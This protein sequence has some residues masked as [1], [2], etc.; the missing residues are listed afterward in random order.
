[1]LWNASETDVP[2]LIDSGCSINLVDRL[3]TWKP[4]VDYQFK[5]GDTPK[6]HGLGTVAIDERR[7]IIIFKDGPILKIPAVVADLINLGVDVFFSEVCS[8]HAWT[9]ATR[10]AWCL[11][12]A[13]ARA[14][15]T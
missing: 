3:K 13:S 9:G 4:G 6:L 14:S 7:I 11:T 2:T 15:I 8:E 12:P 1:M 10:P 5:V